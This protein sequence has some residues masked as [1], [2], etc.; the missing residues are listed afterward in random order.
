MKKK[1]Y[2]CHGLSDYIS[3]LMLVSHH[4]VLFISVDY[5]CSC[6]MVDTLTVT[7]V[8]KL[9]GDRDWATRYVTPDD[10]ESVA[11]AASQPDENRKFLFVG[12]NSKRVEINS[13]RVGVKSTLVGVVSMSCRS[14]VLSGERTLVQ[15]HSIVIQLFFNSFFSQA[16]DSTWQ[17]NWKTIE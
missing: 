13:R 7:N 1:E 3:L 17:P 5:D 8:R 15:F 10:N 4:F 2:F 9:P 14:S 6:E 11:K 12:V 16:R